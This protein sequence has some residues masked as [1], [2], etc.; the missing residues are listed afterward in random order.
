[1]TTTHD[2]TTRR[3]KLFRNQ[4]NLAVRIP[5]DWINPS[6]EISEVELS[7][8]G[9]TITV[10]PVLLHRAGEVLER[11]QEQLHQNPLLTAELETWET[12]V[13]AFPEPVDLDL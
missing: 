10:R 8:D 12:P 5:T 11:L 6:G 4:R 1:M 9:N 2:K 3:A 7:Y 13:D